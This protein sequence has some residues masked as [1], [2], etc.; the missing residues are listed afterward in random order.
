MEALET[1]KAART[2]MQVQ[3]KNFQHLEGNMHSD[4]IVI[5]AVAQNAS[6]LV[7]VITED[8]LDSYYGEDRK[9]VPICVMKDEF[10]KLDKSFLRE[11]FFDNL[12]RLT[13]ITE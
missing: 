11:M 4:F 13:I 9:L 7:E 1:L 12:E 6:Y 10:W 2:C 5:E 3:T 8:L